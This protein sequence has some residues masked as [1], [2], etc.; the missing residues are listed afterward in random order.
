MA[1]SSAILHSFLRDSLKEKTFAEISEDLLQYN[2]AQCGLIQIDF[3]PL[4]NFEHL[5]LLLKENPG[6]VFY[7]NQLFYV[8]TK[9]QIIKELFEPE[10][11]K[12]LAHFQQLKAAC[13]PDYKRAKGRQL[14][15]VK[16]LTG[17]VF[18]EHRSDD[19]L[20]SLNFYLGILSDTDKV[21]FRYMNEAQKEKL[22]VKL[23]ITLLLLLAQEQHEQEYQ[24]TENIRNYETQ[25]RRCLDFLQ[26]LD[27][28]YQS[29]TYSA[30]FEYSDVHLTKYLGIPLG[31]LMARQMVDMSGNNLKE[32]RDSL[33]GMTDEDLEKIKAIT[34][35]SGGD[36]KKIRNAMDD[37]NYW[38]LYWVWG[39]T[40][41][42]TI[43]EL[44]PENSA[45]GASDTIRTPDP[46]TGALSWGL[47]YARFAMNLG[48]LL[49]HTIRG[50][51]MSKEEAQTPWQDR[52]LTQWDQRKFTL[53]NDSIW[54]SANLICYF[55]LTGKG[56]LGTAGDAVTL[57]LL[58]FDIV[59]SVWDFEEQK[60]KYNKAM[61]QYEE[62]IQ[63]LK[64]QL[65]RFGN[66]EDLNDADLKQKRCI[67][68]QLNAL[69]REKSKCE[70]EWQL[71]KISLINNIAYAVGLMMAFMVLTMPFMPIAA[72]VMASM[73]I[74][75][76]VLCL[77]FTVINNAV[78]GGIELYKTYK[79]IQEQKKDNEEKINE[80]LKL[81][82]RNPN[83]NS[84]EKKLLYLEIKKC[85]A[86]TEYQK[87]MMAYQ[88][89]I[90]ARNIIL[91]TVI[92]ALILMSIILLPTGIGAASLLI[93]AGIVLA[94]GIA[95]QLVINAL[96]KPKEKKELE[97]DEDEYEAFCDELIEN[98]A[99]T[100]RSLN[101]FKNYQS[102]GKKGEVEKKI[103]EDSTDFH[104]P[105]LI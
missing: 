16:S 104:D 34:K 45:N 35:T 60:T 1:T 67:K 51:W 37:T 27:P 81:L 13:S 28:V 105:L 54:G 31:Q 26:A 41:L 88:S 56:A 74:A 20:P 8:D 33:V 24:K 39:S 90:L 11:E 6:I 89:V 79:T 95:S 62:D 102:P 98:E 57:G 7:G 46:Y 53:L 75:G 61:L 36:T 38:R 58:I 12:L 42:K 99:P 30:L 78:K 100:E 64:G 72:P 103:N 80:L 29:M 49:K 77:A 4:T 65:A 66:D 91:E 44:I 59:M 19:F 25:I 92:P 9:E 5:K 69:K 94:I 3:H 10:D 43:I 73:M 22:R 71:Q 18:A 82:K 68:S 70:R 50:P 93:A 15:W 85:Q 52:F 97:F 101:F 83:L 87:Q 23:Q 76:A 14:D 21:M 55:W 84:D 96:L 86:E 63:R 32:I 48:L 2:R 47:Y 17:R 40:F